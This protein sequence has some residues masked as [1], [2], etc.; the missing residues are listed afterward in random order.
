M[1]FLHYVPHV[2]LMV[3]IVCT[4]AML[5]GYPAAHWIGG[6]LADFLSFLPKEKFQKPQ[7]ALGI[8]ATKAV[9]GDLHGAVEAYEELLVDHPHEQEIYCRLLEIVMG[10]LHLDEYAEDVLRRGLA[11]LKLPSEK[12]VLINLSES[13]RSGSYHPF[14]HFD[15]RQT[16]PEVKILPPLFTG[17]R[18][19]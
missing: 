2:C 16:P 1:A 19:G 3:A 6:R 14:R 13:I 7:P 10:P 5:A 15:P 11:N 4:I 18:P 8:P 9:R 12:V 17:P